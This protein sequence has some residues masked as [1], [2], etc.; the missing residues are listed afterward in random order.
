MDW[1]TITPHLEAP[2]DPSAIKPPPQGKF[3]E[4]VDGLHVIREANRIF[5]FNGWSYTITRLDM[6]SRIECQDR[7]SNPQV[8]VSYACTVR[9]DVGGVMREGA[10]VGMGIAK[11]DNEA[12]AHESAYKEAETD[13]MKRAL[14]TFGNTFGL[15]LYEKDRN[16]RE[17]GKPEPTPAETRDALKKK[18]QASSAD[19]LKNAWNTNADFR[20][21]VAALPPAMRYELRTAAMGVV[22]GDLPEINP[23]GEE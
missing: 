10:A 14:R 17:V 7:N 13:A 20:A 5:G 18:I 9:V 11:A 8:R 19:G 3:G 21:K 2:L 1:D 6:A 4:Y 16:K 12:D 15:A 23:E 22:E